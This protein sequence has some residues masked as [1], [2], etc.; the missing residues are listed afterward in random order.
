MVI[1]SSVVLSTPVGRIRKGKRAGVV[2]LRVWVCNVGLVIGFEDGEADGVTN[3]SGLNS[4]EKAS[5]RC[6]C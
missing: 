4:R 3:A 2:A 6:R 1:Y 5:E